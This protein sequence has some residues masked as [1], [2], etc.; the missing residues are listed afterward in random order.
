MT[1]QSTSYVSQTQQYQTW[2]MNEREVLL[3]VREKLSPHVYNIFLHCFL[4]LVFLLFILEKIVQEINVLQFVQALRG[5]G[6]P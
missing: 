5:D 6:V 3:S 4:T 2:M 1:G